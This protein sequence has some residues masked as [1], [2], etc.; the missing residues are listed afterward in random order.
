MAA[1]TEAAA[2]IH[3]ALVLFLLW[4][5]IFW[6]WPSLRL[7]MGQ[8]SFP[9]HAPGSHASARPPRAARR[10]ARNGP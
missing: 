4:V 9:K 7:D 8:I 3:F 10:D 1:A 5:L 6:M 2:A